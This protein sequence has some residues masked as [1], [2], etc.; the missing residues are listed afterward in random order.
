LNYGN[1]KF[2]IS[3]GLHRCTF[4]LFHVGIPTGYGLDDR[5]SIPGGGWEVFST[6]PRPD[7]FWGPPSLLSNGYRKLFPWT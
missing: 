4:T 5:G 6:P 7:W 1:P 3:V 2:I